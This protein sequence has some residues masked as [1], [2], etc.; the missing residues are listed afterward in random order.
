MS[1]RALVGA[2]SLALQRNYSTANPVPLGEH[3]FS[4]ERKTKF[5]ERISKIRNLRPASSKADQNPSKKAAVL[6][7]FVLVDDKPRYLIIVKY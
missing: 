4:L 7:P 2:A 6:V 5:N 1:Y 3:F